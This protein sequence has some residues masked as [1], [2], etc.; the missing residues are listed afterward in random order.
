MEDFRVFYHWMLCKHDRDDPLGGN[1]KLQIEKMKIGN[2][3]SAIFNFPFHATVF[4]RLGEPLTYQP[5][6]D[7]V[8]IVEEVFGIVHAVVVGEHVGF[9]KKFVGIGAVAGVVEK[10]VQALQIG[11]AGDHGFRSLFDG[12]SRL[13]YP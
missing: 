12:L 4:P 7:A 1:W 3:Q 2:F 6:D 10:D 9:A 11:G 13:H 8:P 5:F